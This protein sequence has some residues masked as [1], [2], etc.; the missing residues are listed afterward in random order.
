MKIALAG[1]RDETDFLIG[2][3]KEKKHKLIVINE[4]ELFCRYLSKTHQIPV[5]CGDLSKS[6]VLEDAGIR[7][8]DIFLGLCDH[9][10]DN[11]ALCIAAKKIHRVKRAVCVVSNPKNVEIFK[12][13]GIDIVISDM[14]MIA[15]Y[16]LSNTTIEER[17]TSAFVLS[18]ERV[19]VS[20]L[21]VKSGDPAANKK[22][23][24]IVM[25]KQTIICCVMRG[26]DVIIP[27]GATQILVGDHIFVISPTEIQADVIAALTEE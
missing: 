18:D 7:N 16:I 20:E 2:L 17:L 25:P 27:N 26:E 4:N 3:L 11:F 9:D 1:G 24:N 10:E 14:Y 13:L 12:S 8:A 6:Y 21:T 15:N 22:V 5:F 23:M 19:I